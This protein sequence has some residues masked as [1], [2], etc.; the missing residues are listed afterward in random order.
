MKALTVHVGT[1]SK[2]SGDP[3]YQALAHDQSV[4]ALV[5]VLDI[6]NR[7]DDPRFTRR[8]NLS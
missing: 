8:A 3:T 1:R 7:Q 6:F 4:F 2:I 5:S